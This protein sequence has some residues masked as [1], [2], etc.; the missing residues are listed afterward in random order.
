MCRRAVVLLY[1]AA[2]VTRVPLRVL[3]FRRF[4]TLTDGKLQFRVMDVR[5]HQLVEAH[6]RMHVVRHTFNADGSYDRFFVSS[7]M[8][9]HEPDD[10]VGAYMLLCLPQFVAH[11]IDSDSPLTPTKEYM[12]SLPGRLSHPGDLTDEDVVAFMHRSHMEIIVFVEGID[13]TTSDTLQCRH[14]Y[15]AVDIKVGH[16]HVPCVSVERNGVPKVN[17]SHFHETCPAVGTDA[18]AAEDSAIVNIRPVQP[19]GAGVGAGAA[20]AAAAAAAV[21]LGTPVTGG[22]AGDHRM[23]ATYGSNNA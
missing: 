19:L 5:K 4:A 20:A 7:Y 23:P 10:E 9:T 8:R 14:S 22:K 16:R 15:T 17:L 13:S 2:R 21:G 6:V 1:Y 18:S 11:N 12:A 3:P